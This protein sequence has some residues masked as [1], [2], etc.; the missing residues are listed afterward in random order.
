[1]ITSGMS[2]SEILKEFWRNYETLLHL[3]VLWD[4]LEDI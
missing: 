1:M 4:G 2:T 3:V